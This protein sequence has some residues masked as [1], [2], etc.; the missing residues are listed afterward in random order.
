MS[1][2]RMTTPTTTDM[3]AMAPVE[4]PVD[5]DDATL[6]GGA[7]LVAARRRVGLD[8][9]CMVVL[10]GEID[11]GMEVDAGAVVLVAAA[12][13]KSPDFHLICKG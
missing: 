4:R 6:V 8:V 7:E 5:V 9:V 12:V 11:V 13:A 10:A 1:A 2:A 3:A